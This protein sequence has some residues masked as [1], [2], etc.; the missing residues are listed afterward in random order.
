MRGGTTAVRPVVISAS[1]SRSEPP[2]SAGPDFSAPG[3]RGSTAPGASTASPS[4]GKRPLCGECRTRQRG[5]QCPG[6][7]SWSGTSAP[8]PSFWRSVRPG[9]QRPQVRCRLWAVSLD[10]ISRAWSTAAV[11]SKKRPRRQLGAVHRNSDLGG[12]RPLMTLLCSGRRRP[13]SQSWA[14]AACR[15]TSPRGWCHHALFVWGPVRRGLRRVCGGYRAAGRQLSLKYSIARTEPDLACSFCSSW[16][17]CWSVSAASLANAD[18]RHPPE[19]SSGPCWRYAP[20][21]TRHRELAA[22]WAWSCSPCAV[23]AKRF[24]VRAASVV[25]FRRFLVLPI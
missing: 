14:L 12:C 8:P 21:E 7:S 15:P 20:R 18:R 2:P 11:L 10:L 16:T 9:G 3:F 5:V 19:R 23:T 22:C 1:T 6:R 4:A 13:W 24:C 25:S 17:A